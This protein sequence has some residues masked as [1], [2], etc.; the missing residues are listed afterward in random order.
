MT[1]ID[2]GRLAQGMPN[3]ASPQTDFGNRLNGEGS[4][5]TPLTASPSAT[6]YIVPPIPT[7]V[8]PAKTFSGPPAMR[9]QVPLQPL[10][11]SDF[12]RERRAADT[13]LRH[14]RVEHQRQDEIAA[15]AQR[16]AWRVRNQPA[17]GEERSTLSSLGERLAAF[18]MDPAVAPASGILAQLV[19]MIERIDSLRKSL[20]AHQPGQILSVGS[21]VLNPAAARRQLATLENGFREGLARLEVEVS[22]L[23]EARDRESGAGAELGLR[24]LSEVGLK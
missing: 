7:V 16:V 3:T 1:L 13:A 18:G 19:P 5:A 21:E 20:G 11:S 17:A 22:S 10:P 2:T 15:E 9:V 24:S 23:E 6:R 4:T 14:Q 12:T 8:A